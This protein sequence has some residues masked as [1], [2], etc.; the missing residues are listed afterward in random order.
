M[1][2]VVRPASVP[3][4][5]NP[6]ERGTDYVRRIAKAKAAAITFEA[7]DIVLSADTAVC[8][9]SEVFGK[10]VDE[11]DA[12][13]MLRVLAGRDHWVYTGICLRTKTREIVDISATRVTFLPM[14]DEEIAEYTR[15][16]EPTDKAGAYAIQGFASKFV[17]RIEGCY[18]N[19]VGL[20]VSLVYRHLKTL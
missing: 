8:A 18:Q 15:S 3:E 17:S 20:P 11:A 1:E 13:R 10:P 4:H 14:T 6:G 12:S 2:H 5:R 9:D 19:V 7:S 16:G